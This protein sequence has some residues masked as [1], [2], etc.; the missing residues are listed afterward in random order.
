MSISFSHDTTFEYRQEQALALI[1]RSEWLCR[2]DGI[3]VC[4]VCL[5]PTATAKAA[6]LGEI[7]QIIEDHNCRS[8]GCD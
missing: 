6:E 7:Q 3:T 5:N 1:D 2:L 4:K 8:G